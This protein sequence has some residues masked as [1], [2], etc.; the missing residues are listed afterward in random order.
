L[1]LA[2]SLLKAGDTHVKRLATLPIAMM[3]IGTAIASLPAALLMRRLG[4]RTGFLTGATLGITG[5]LRERPA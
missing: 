4:R 3:V 2:R 5:S 1:R